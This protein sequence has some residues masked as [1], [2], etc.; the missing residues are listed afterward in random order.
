MEN[1]KPY[2]YCKVK[3]RKTSGLW[4]VERNTTDDPGAGHHQ[5]IKVLIEVED[6]ND[7]PQFNVTVKDVMLAENAP[8]GTWVE[9]VAAVDPDSTPTKKIW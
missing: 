5:S 1:V 6:T 8:T 7:P 2:F 9:T 3:E 4:D